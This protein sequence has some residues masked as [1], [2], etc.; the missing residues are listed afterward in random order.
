MSGGYKYFSHELEGFYLPRFGN[1]LIIG[2]T[3]T[4]GIE[5]LKLK[6]TIKSSPIC[7]PKSNFRAKSFLEEL[8]YSEYLSIPRMYLIKRVDWKPE[9][10]FSRG[11]GYLG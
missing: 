3:D 9:G 10:V 8:G 4:A 2:K 5:L 11:S 6:L 7:I 1:G